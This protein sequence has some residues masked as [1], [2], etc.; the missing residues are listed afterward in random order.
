MFLQGLVVALAVVLPFLRLASSH[1]QVFLNLK[2]APYDS[3]LL[4]PIKDIRALDTS[5]YTTLI[6]P[7]FPYHT[8]RIRQNGASFCD[9]SV[10]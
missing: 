6:H 1:E 10:K 8:V 5:E 2:A 3:N 9:D 4:T 7:S